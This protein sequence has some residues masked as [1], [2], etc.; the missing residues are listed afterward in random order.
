MEKPKRQQRA[1]E[2]S[3][4][5]RLT[6]LIDSS[7]ILIYSS[8]VPR[9]LTPF[10]C[11]NWI[12]RPKETCLPTIFGVQPLPFTATAVPWRWVGVVGVHSLAEGAYL[13]SIWR[14][15]GGINGGDYGWIGWAWWAFDDS[16][17][18]DYKESRFENLRYEGGQ[19]CA[20]SRLCQ[21]K[22]GSSSFFLYQCFHDASES[23]PSV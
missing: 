21:C 16:V 23:R 14:F 17:A 11:K 12:W 18:I 5:R 20:P 22:L 13:S 4:K 19:D 15:G 6:V 9:L 2:V 7:A 10:G 1:D 3:T 8:D